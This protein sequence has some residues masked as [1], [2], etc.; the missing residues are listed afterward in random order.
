MPA[1][2]STLE[3]PARLSPP[4]TS[5]GVAAPKTSLA[6][7]AARQLEQF[8]VFPPL[9]EEVEIA[10]WSSHRR[11]LSGNFH[12][13]QMLHDGR[14]LVTVG[15]A[16]GHDTDTMK[17]ALVAQSAWA[18][19]R[20][21]ALHARDAATLLSLA[22][23]SLWG[24]PG[25]KVHADVAVALVDPVGAHVSLSLAGDPLVWRIRAAKAERLASDQ[26][27]LGAATDISYRELPLDLAIRERLLIVADDPLRRSHRLMAALAA[28]CTNPSAESHRRMTA[29][30]AVARIR[31][32]YEQAAE[33]DP[34]TSASILAVR[35]R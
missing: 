22:A 13:W 11:R 5:T 28:S 2:P 17:A 34:L 4:L 29:G 35:C 16:V 20:A 15:H 33:T 8:P 24:I 14:I 21:H 6:P 27:P 18:A 19:I 31:K 23:R 25:E 9:L 32:N 7:A 1:T 3:V 30:D 12:D 10:G 26:P